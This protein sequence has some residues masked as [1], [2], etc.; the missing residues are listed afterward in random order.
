MSNKIP[1]A[2]CGTNAVAELYG[3]YLCPGC[4]MSIVVCEDE[5]IP[6]REIDPK[7]C[8]ELKPVDEIKYL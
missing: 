6:V 7:D 8:S 1:C 4:L 5:A 3:E 2:H